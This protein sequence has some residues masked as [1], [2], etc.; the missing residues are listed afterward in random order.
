[1]LFAILI[2][3]SETE[4]AALS[5]E[6]ETALL[7]RHADLRR[8]LTAQERLGPF[9]RLQA[10]VAQT[11]RRYKDRRYVTDGPFTE[12]KEQLMGMYVVDYPTIEDVYDSTDR[13]DFDG[14]VF[15]IRPLTYFNTGPAAPGER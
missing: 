1:M 11:V 13:L 3:G 4:Y 6:D 8:D 15:E 9:M 5:P 7:D 14:A 2:Y 12:T 10:G